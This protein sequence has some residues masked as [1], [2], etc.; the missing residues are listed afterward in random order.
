MERSVADRTMDGDAS[1]TVADTAK[2]VS[3]VTFAPGEPG[4]KV[5]GDIKSEAELDAAILKQVEYYFSDA[6]FPNDKFMIAETAKS[7]EQWISL[8]TIATFNRMKAL[9]P[10]HELSIL[11]RALTP[12]SV[13]ELSEDGTQVGRVP[14]RWQKSLGGKTYSN[15]QE[16]ISYGR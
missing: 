7:P 5:G 12:S 6:N 15:R 8:S 14:S 3:A 16:L 13:L 1:K 2:T 4:E 9:N 11:V 10:S